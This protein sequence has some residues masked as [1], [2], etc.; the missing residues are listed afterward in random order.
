MLAAVWW[1]VGC[2]CNSSTCMGG[3]QTKQRAGCASDCCRWGSMLQFVY[4]FEGMLGNL[5]NALAPGSAYS[6][7][8]YCCL[9]P[10]TLQ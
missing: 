7:C 8:M 5:R 4:H 2:V 10:C 1:W 9:P 6:K 3:I